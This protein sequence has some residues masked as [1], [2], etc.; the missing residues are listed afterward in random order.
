MRTWL[1][2]LLL[3]G[4]SSARAADLA[5]GT[6]L[7]SRYWD[8]AKGHLADRLMLDNG[9]WVADWSNRC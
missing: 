3:V 2:V 4:A 5:T 8:P 1:A 7:A 9:V 6:S